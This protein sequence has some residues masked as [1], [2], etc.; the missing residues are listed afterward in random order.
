LYLQRRLSE[1]AA[2]RSD[3]E[4]DVIWPTD[5]EVSLAVTKCSGVFVVASIIV[6]FVI[7]PNHTLQDRLHII[8]SRPDSTVNEGKSG[9]D[10]TY[11][12]IFLE[13]FEDIKID[14]TDFF[15]R[16]C[17]VLSSIVLAF[18]PLSYKDL[19]IILDLPPKSVWN[20]IR[21]LHLVLIVPKSNSDPPRVCHKSFPDYLTD[22]N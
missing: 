22:R 9:L 18:N 11:D 2:Q 19:A 17:L 6:R 21:S 5:E 20:T 15:N 12:Q 13:G 3:Y 14:D 10:E 8:I 16:L 4:V 7:S 1:I